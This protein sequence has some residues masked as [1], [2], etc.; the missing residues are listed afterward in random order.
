MSDNINKNKQL[1]EEVLHASEETLKEVL[2]AEIVV[3][4]RPLFLKNRTLT[5]SCSN[6]MAAQEISQHQQEIVDKI[7]AKLGKNEVDRVRYLT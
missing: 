4:T 6:S 2:S 5:I 7:N 1:D 3:L